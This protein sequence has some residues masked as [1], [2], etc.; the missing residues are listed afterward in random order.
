HLI[1]VIDK[2][3]FGARAIS[4]AEPA[5]QA[6]LDTQAKRNAEARIYQRD[7]WLAAALTLPVFMLAMGG[8]L[9]PALQQW[10]MTVLGQHTNWLIQGALTT[11]VLLGPG[12]G[13]YLRGIPALL[14][15][16][17]DMNSLVAVGTL[18]AWEFSTIATLA[19]GLLPHGT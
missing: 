12:R 5:G 15:A 7:F 19:P 4:S 3:G 2:A 13:F 17:P 8:H 6:S 11:L 1:T 14:H 18:A 10:L 9:V 16:A